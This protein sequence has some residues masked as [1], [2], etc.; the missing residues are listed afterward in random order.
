[1]RGLASGTPWLLDF[2]GKADVAFADVMDSDARSGDK[3]S[4]DDTHKDSGNNLNWSFVGIKIGDT[5]VW[6]GTQ[7]SSW[8]AAGNWSL[9]R[10]PVDTDVIV[11]SAE[12]ACSP[13][14]AEAL[15]LNRLEIA[16]G[17][18]LTLN[19]FS[20]TVTNG[21]ACAGA[22]VCSG[23]ETLTLAGDVTVKTFTAADSTI[24]LAG[25]ANRT[26]DFAGQTLRN[27]EIAGTAGQT[28]LSFSYMNEQAYICLKYFAI[29]V[30]SMSSLRPDDI[31]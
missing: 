17:K 10:A 21:L 28:A 9:E 13:E 1:M 4:V 14:L 20:L 29:D 6:Y 30:P 26:V 12:A 18:S 7:G 15:T 5:N 22:L 24:V 19:G 23:A 25:G 11:I 16:A 8:S 31:M 2:H 27:L 3:V